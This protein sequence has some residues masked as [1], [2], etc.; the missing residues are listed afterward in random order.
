MINSPLRRK[1][2]S[3]AAQAP[4]G[5]E[6]AA[7]AVAAQFTFNLAMATHATL[8]L[9]LALLCATVGVTAEEKPMPGLNVDLRSSRG[10]QAAEWALHASDEQRQAML[11]VTTVQKGDADTLAK[12]L[13]FD[14]PLDDISYDGV[15]ALTAGARKVRLNGPLHDFGACSL[16]F[17]R[18]AP[19]ARRAPPRRRPRATRSISGRTTA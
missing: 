14:V 9:A 5:A 2:C 8:A 15:T 12:L 18:A 16:A 3:A 11:L 17:P 19:R 7:A 4:G 6:A 10:K 1:C 13:E